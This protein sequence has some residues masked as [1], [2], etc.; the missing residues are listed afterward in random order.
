MERRGGKRKAGW[1]LFGLL[2]AADTASV[3]L[4]ASVVTCAPTSG[5]LR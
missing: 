2:L 4:Y 1:G 5:F 3:W